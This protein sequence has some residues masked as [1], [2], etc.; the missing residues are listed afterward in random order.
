MQYLDNQS[1]VWLLDLTFSSHQFLIDGCFPSDFIV[2][3]LHHESLLTQGN[4]TDTSDS[5][6]TSSAS[7]RLDRAALTE[8]LASP[9]RGGPCWLCLLRGRWGQSRSS[10]GSVVA[11]SCE[12]WILGSAQHWASRRS[13][14]REVSPSPAAVWPTGPVPE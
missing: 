1:E 10:A 2:T 7:R 8:D 6:F 13:P 5:I 11:A 14:R 3:K 9:G 4:W 12:A